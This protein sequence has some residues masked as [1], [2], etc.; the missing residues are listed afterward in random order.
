MKTLTYEISKGQFLGE[1]E[2]F[3]TMG[4]PTDSIIHKQITGCGATTLELEFK[5]NS[6]IIEPNLPVILGKANKMNQGKRKHK[7]IL[8]VY[9]KVSI[10]DIKYYI[11]NRKGCKKIVT[12]PEGFEKVIEAI[13]ESVF[14]DYFLLF[15][16]CEKVIQDVAYRGRITDPLNMFFSFQNKAFVSATPIVPSDPRFEKFTQV[17]IKPDYVLQQEIT[18]YPTNNV[19]FQLKK[20]ID[21]YHQYG[22]ETDRKFFIFFKSTQRIKH[23]IQGLKLDDYAIHCSESKVRDLKS[24]GMSKAYGSIT[25]KFSKYNFFTSRFF[26]AVDFDHKVYNCNPIIIM[27]SDPLAIEHSVIDPATEAIQIIGRFRN[28]ERKEG[29]P[30]IEIEKDIYHLTNYNSKLTNLSNE[31]IDGIVTDIQWMHRHIASFRPTLNYPYINKFKYNILKVEGF[32]YFNRDSSR[33]HFM[34]D[35]FRDK[36]LIKGYYN[37]SYT[38]LDKY[39]ELERFEVNSNSKYIKFVLTD[40]HLREMTSTTAFFKLN[41]FVGQRLKELMESQHNID[42]EY[43]EFNLDTLRIS[44]PKQM[45]VIDDYGIDKAAKLEYD[46]NKI[47]D[48][49][50]HDL[51]TEELKEMKIYVNKAFTLKG[52]PADEITEILKKGIELI[53][54][55]GYKANLA[56][57]KRFAKISKRGNVKKVD[58]TIAKGYAITKF[59][60]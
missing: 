50:K 8:G 59:Y 28:P 33:N 2:P 18:V 11:E 15:D 52:Y 6:I 49:Q 54:L 35:N 24:N 20:V 17:I 36:E 7:V 21:S 56:L 57:L 55:K 4:L 51:I 12:T 34:I 13:G 9:D 32:S 27:I 46:I 31:E 53:G 14:K 23:I 47:Q 43:M 37:T 45:A 5:R 44:F 19:V 48:T 58:G 16:E 10:E 41:T 1:L 40:S 30:L 22:E 26:S 29:E 39:R 3:K 60:D 25:Y 42:S 38:L